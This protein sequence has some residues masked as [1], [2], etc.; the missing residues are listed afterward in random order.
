MEK[1]TL[2]QLNEIRKEG[3]RPG[4]VACIIHNKKILLFFKKEYQL[5][6]LPQGGINNK[7]EPGKALERTLI[8]ELGVNFTKQ[9]DF[10][11]VAYLDSDRMEFMPGKHSVGN[12]EDDGGNP[13]EMLGKEYYFSVVE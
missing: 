5:W 6:M 12:L 9:L 2:E 13:I 11:K 4:V 10:E 8:E 7:E 3:F 1:P